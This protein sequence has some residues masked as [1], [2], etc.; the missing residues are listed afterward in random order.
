MVYLVLYIYLKAV[1]CKDTPITKSRY[2]YFHKKKQEQLESIGI[3]WPEEEINP[4]D[5]PHLQSLNTKIVCMGYLL[6]FRRVNKQLKH[7]PYE[8]SKVQEMIMNLEG[9]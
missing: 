2:K 5:F 4:E 7:K 3:T 8:L 1:C 9:F 6:N